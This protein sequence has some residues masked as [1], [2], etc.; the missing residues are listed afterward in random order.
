MRWARA[1]QEGTVASP[2]WQPPLKNIL[3]VIWSELI[4]PNRSAW[5]GM[6]VLWVAMLVIN[7]QLS[8]HRTSEAGASTASSQE[9]IQAWEEQN[10]VLAEL[11][12]PEFV[13]PAPPPNLPRPRSEREEDWVIL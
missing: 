6:A 12:Q 7:G 3:R 10:R 5:T 11:T 2:L 8:G 13:V 1:V 4:R 9:M